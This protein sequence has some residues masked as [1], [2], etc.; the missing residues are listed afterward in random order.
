MDELGVTAAFKESF[1]QG[2]RVG[3][4][5]QLQSKVIP[6]KALHSLTGKLNNVA[7]LLLV[8]RSFLHPLWAALYDPQSN[9][10]QNT[11]WIKQLLP[12]LR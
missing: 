8:L 7:G 9:A 6:R 10:S 5:A 1:L 2:I 4:Q 12:T 3:L 11:V